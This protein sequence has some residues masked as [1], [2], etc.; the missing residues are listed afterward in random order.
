MLP[1]EQLPLLG[2]RGD[3]ATHA[4]AHDPL[5]Q[6]HHDTAA[7]GQFSTDLCD[8]CAG[9]QSYAICLV[10][11]CVPCVGHA[12]V[13]DAASGH[14]SGQSRPYLIYTLALCPF[15]CLA[16]TLLGSLARG[17]LRRQYNMADAPCN[18]VHFAHDQVPMARESTR[19]CRNCTRL[20]QSRQVRTY[21]H[22]AGPQLRDLAPHLKRAVHCNLASRL[23]ASAKL[24]IHTGPVVRHNHVTAA[25]RADVRMHMC[26]HCCSTAQ[27]MRH[28]RDLEGPLF[29][30]RAT[31]APGTEFVDGVDLAS[32]CLA[33]CLGGL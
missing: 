20:A 4:T 24:V 14:T 5:E 31:H 9:P 16:Q 32:F 27:E 8:C 26:C 25:A 29:R 19:V 11:A 10:S 30:K 6:A 17:K 2:P 33:D 21:M 23:V 1:D 18:G 28:V 22:L 13:S 12:I 7:S 15:L 3:D